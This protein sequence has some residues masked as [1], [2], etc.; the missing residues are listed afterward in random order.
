MEN[1]LATRCLQAASHLY[2]CHLTSKEKL[3]AVGSNFGERK[4]E[5]KFEGRERRKKR[6]RAKDR[7]LGIKKKRELERSCARVSSIHNLKKKLSS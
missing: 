3:G 1:S 6:S 4:K 7:D 2:V 5:Q